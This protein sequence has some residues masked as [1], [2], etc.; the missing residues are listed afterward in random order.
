MGRGPEV[1]KG[2]DGKGQRDTVAHRHQEDVPGGV[3]GQVLAEGEVQPE[4]GG[5]ADHGDD[6]P[7]EEA[8]HR[9]EGDEG[10]LEDDPLAPREGEL[11]EVEDAA[12][13]DEEGDHHGDEPD[14]QQGEEDALDKEGG[15]GHAPA[16]QGDHEEAEADGGEDEDAVLEDDPE[17][18]EPG[19]LQVVPDHARPAAHEEAAHNVHQDVGAHVQEAPGHHVEL[20]EVVP[21]VNL[22]LEESD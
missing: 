19:V 15:A 10:D 12:A 21:G 9:G 22:E 17:V 1:G 14:Q 4:G 16:H 11:D 13:E 18:P 7:G 20:A 3:H 8:G 2:V 5:H 6:D